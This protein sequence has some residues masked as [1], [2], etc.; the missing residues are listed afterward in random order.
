[1]TEM[2]LEDGTMSVVIVIMRGKT[3]KKVYENF[4][5]CIKDRDY[6]SVTDKII[7]EIHDD[8]TVKYNGGE[9]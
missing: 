6:E 5:Q 4:I 7:E 3:M 9:H 8:E 2:K 1:M